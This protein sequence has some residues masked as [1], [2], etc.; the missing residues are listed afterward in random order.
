[1]YALLRRFALCACMRVITYVC[2]R[3]GAY[4][5]I[6]S[7]NWLALQLLSYLQLRQPTSPP[8]PP[9]PQPTPPRPTDEC[10]SPPV[11]LTCHE[12][13]DVSPLSPDPQPATASNGGTPALPNDGPSRTHWSWSSSEDTSPTELWSANDI[14]LQ[15]LVDAMEQRLREI[16][17]QNYDKMRFVLFFVGRVTIPTVVCSRLLGKGG[18][19]NYATPTHLQSINLT[20][21]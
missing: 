8:P 5:Y 1:M 18:T 6:T 9:Q 4:V 2:M 17:G 20:I 21:K 3:A 13:F 19:N 10:P 14:V 11:S 7:F 16:K 15:R 12:V